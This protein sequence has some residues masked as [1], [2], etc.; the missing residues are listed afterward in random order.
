[1]RQ[2]VYHLFKVSSAKYPSCQHFFKIKVLKSTLCIKQQFKAMRSTL[3]TQS[4]AQEPFALGIKT[5]Q[6]LTENASLL[7]GF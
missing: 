1:M 5:Q 6:D 3:T 2:R 7:A 4:E